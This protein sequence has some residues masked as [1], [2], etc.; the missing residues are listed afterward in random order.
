MLN[1]HLVAILMG[2]GFI[3]VKLIQMYVF[4]GIQT[5]YITKSSKLGR[6]MLV[7]C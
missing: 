6:T 3:V 7:I 1:I 4:I 5:S 2:V